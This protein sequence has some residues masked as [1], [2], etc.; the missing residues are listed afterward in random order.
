[1]IY[2]AGCDSTLWV[3]F[4]LAG[5]TMRFRCKECGALH[6]IPDE[7]LGKGKRVRCQRCKAITVVRPGETR[8]EPE[9]AKPKVPDLDE[10][11]DLDA[12]M[13]APTR[14]ASID[15]VL[16]ADE[17]GGQGSDAS[18]DAATRVA[19]SDE[20]FDGGGPAADDEDDDGIE[21]YDAVD[22]EQRP[23]VEAPTEKEAAMDVQ[24]V[25]V[26]IPAG[27]EPD[28]PKPLPADPSL[29]ETLFSDSLM[30]GLP[31]DRTGTGEHT[32][33]P[34]PARTAPAPRDPA[35][36]IRGGRSERG[37]KL[38]WFLAI[39]VVLA[40]GAFGAMMVF[41]ELGFLPGKERSP[42]GSPPAKPEKPKKP[43]P[44]KLPVDV[45]P[46]TLLLL[47]GQE[48][49]TSKGQ[50]AGFLD[51]AEQAE[52]RGEI[53]EARL[54]AA[55]SLAHADGEEARTLL[56]RISDAPRPQLVWRSLPGVRCS[57]LAYAPDGK[58]LA[59]AT[60]EH[61]LVWD[62]ASGREIQRFDG[63]DGAVRV[64]AFSPDG[65]RLATGGE[66]RV[67]RLWSL[68]EPEGAPVEMS[69]HRQAITAVSFSAD[70]KRIATGSADRA[71]RL[72][73]VEGAVQEGA[74]LTGHRKPVT[75]VL[76]SAD[77]SRLYSASR[78]RKV[79]IWD[80]VESKKL[81]AL[82]GHRKAVTALA[83]SPAGGLAS[84]A[85]DGEVRL[86]QPDV[87]DAPARAI[88]AHEGAVAGLAFLEDG[89]T[90]ASAGADRQLRL[91]QAESGEAGRVLKHDG[92]IIALATTS[93]GKRVA[94]AGD[95]GT[96]LVWDPSQGKAVARLSGMVEPVN[97]IDISNDRRMVAGACEDGTVRVW[98]T[99]TGLEQV[100]RPRPEGGA[101]KSVRFSPKGKYLATAHGVSAEVWE[102]PGFRSVT[103]F[104]TP[105]EV[106]RFTPDGFKIAIGG[107]EP[108]VGIWDVES[109]EEVETLDGPERGI[110]ALL[111]G[112]G[113]K[114]LVAGSSDGTARIWYI[115]TDDS[116]VRSGSARDPVTSLAFFARA[117]EV[118]FGTERAGIR[119]WVLAKAVESK[120]I[121]VGSAVRTLAAAPDGRTF[122]S[123]HEDGR[124]ILW[125]LATGEPLA[126]LP[127]HRAAVSGLEFSGDGRLLAT[128]S[129]DG[130]LRLWRMLGPREGTAGRRSGQE[131]LMAERRSTRLTLIDG[132][133]AS[134][135]SLY[136]TWF[137][138]TH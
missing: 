4:W 9:P 103:H 100:F 117:G 85:E 38:L 16:A 14:I 111:Y 80:T 18:M 42:V 21:A 1:L 137:K 62:L 88:E 90:L 138:V 11:E 98:S 73:D 89:K 91:W 50:A 128:A 43:A 99:K 110:T 37:H 104:D 46:E 24:P 41:P 132:E 87:V 106:L 96:V 48:Q 2:T 71:V 114:F 122:A 20:L 81:R 109:G 60:G 72:W 44:P 121:K 133:P 33:V 36:V 82:E 76:F 126:R 108:R 34:E 102:Y 105:A 124:V 45:I 6:E 77:G 23:T 28:R 64:V 116:E 51:L 66:D 112:P 120:P 127:A 101:M 56:A 10:R 74:R 93:D 129:R 123:G 78:D 25:A 55:A 118:L 58:R 29:S 69:G 79:L 54:L 67:L 39:V 12:E 68:A 86:W 15:E 52:A 135:P 40:V 47:P 92:A 83:L 113:G 31:D 75:A 115:G 61:A 35:P 63:G 70:G 65:A 49:A 19:S 59:C 97:A 32:A 119:R 13:E 95:D 7:R 107:A 53:L 131:L 26:D 134:D 8:P 30:E 3:R 136:R 5:L 27:S 130:T 84:G 125:N 57:A 94:S 17:S 22:W